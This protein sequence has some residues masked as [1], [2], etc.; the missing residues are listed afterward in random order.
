MFT[1]LVQAVGRVVAISP[2]PAGVSLRIDPGA[3]D[4]RPTLGDSISISGCCLTIAEVAPAAWRFDV[5]PETLSKT[6]LGGLVP[7]SPVNLEHA[8]RASDLLGGHFVQGH[9]DAVA[10][11]ARVKAD[12]SDWRVA[13]DLPEHLRP[14]AAPK[15]S[16][17]IDG[18]SLTI[19]ALTPTGLEVAL[20]PTT[21]AKTTLAN[22]HP[23]CQVNIE[24]DMLAKQVVHV[25][26]NYRDLLRPG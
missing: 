1:G 13:V 2:A 15:G 8:L 11:V 26:R 24:A 10:T 16:I 23:G 22:L 9:V 14:Y 4:H 25:M 20:I 6:I 3:W 17:A 7:G 12:P 18:V 21:L 19:A 5:V